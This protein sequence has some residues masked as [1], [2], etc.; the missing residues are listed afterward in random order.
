[1]QNHCLPIVA[2]THTHAGNSFTH[3]LTY[4]LTQKKV[5]NKTGMRGVAMM[6]RSYYSPTLIT[7]LILW[8]FPLNISARINRRSVLNSSFGRLYSTSPVVPA[9]KRLT[10]IKY[11]LCTDVWWIHS[12]SRFGWPVKEH[13]ALRT[14]PLN[15]ILIEIWPLSTFG[16]SSMK[17]PTSPTSTERY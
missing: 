4:S 17:F 11:T 6:N 7:L 14:K 12:Q 9:V 3:S 1:M 16:V 15:R 2:L 8:T 10:I 13:R 5:V